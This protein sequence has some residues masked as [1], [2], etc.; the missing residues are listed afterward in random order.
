MFCLMETSGICTSTT[1]PTT[2]AQ[3]R[4]GLCHPIRFDARAGDYYRLQG[5]QQRSRVRSPT[6]RHPNGKRLSGEK[7]CNSFRFPA[8][9][10]PDYWE[11]KA[12]HPKMAQYLEKVRKQL[13]AF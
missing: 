4:H 6:S 9:H 2:K 5:I 7:A 8:N 11:Y 3:S 10:Q 1:H 12:K 13:E